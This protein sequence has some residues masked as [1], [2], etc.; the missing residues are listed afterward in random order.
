M[1]AVTGRAGFWQLDRAHQKRA[2]QA[3]RDE[4]GSAPTLEPS[5]LAATVPDVADQLQRRVLLRGVWLGANTVF[6]DNRQMRDRPGFYVVTPLLLAG[7]DAVLVQRGWVPRD[8]QDR[9]RLPRLDTPAGPVEI[10]G[11]V[12][13]WPSH[14][15]SLGADAP[16]PIRQNLT[17]DSFTAEV[18]RDL[19]PLSIA[20]LDQAGQ[21]TDGLLRDWPQPALD[22]SKHYGYAVQWF[23]F[24]AMIAGLYVW[25]QLVRPWLARRAG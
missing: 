4:R 7:G 19:R 14:L 21:A 8:M 11:R 23:T 13:P 3:Q 15:T 17:L 5:E 16:G 24:C 2:L 12:S 22:L 6:L 20:E 1:M 18:G 9:S 10:Y 25:F